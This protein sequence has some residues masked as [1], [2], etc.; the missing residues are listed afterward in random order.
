MKGHAMKLF[1]I[2]LVGALLAL[3]VPALAITTNVLPPPG[4][5]VVA[6]KSQ[7]ESTA[8]MRDDSSG[9][10]KGAVQGMSPR[11][12]LNVNGQTLKFDPQ[13]VKIIGT[14]GKQRT[15][16]ALQKGATISFTL[17]PRDASRQRVGVIY[18]K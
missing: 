3:P 4:A 2:P 12:T 13:Q 5:R 8:S 15:L 14:D 17:D 18:L 1:L 16:G 10:R 11:G 7:Q 6:P 9:L